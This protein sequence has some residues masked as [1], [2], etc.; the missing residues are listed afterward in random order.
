MSKLSLK[1]HLQGMSKEH[2]IEFVLEVYQNSKQAKEFIE[3]K[4]Q[5][6]EK[7]QFEKYKNI[8]LEE[9]YP[10]KSRRDPKIVSQFAKKLL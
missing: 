9:F 8:I 2:V 3:Y 5:P 10:S 6:N 1:K 7:E 4:L